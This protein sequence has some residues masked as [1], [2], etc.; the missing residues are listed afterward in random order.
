MPASGQPW[1]PLFASRSPLY[2]PYLQLLTDWSE[3][4]NWPD[5]EHYR[6]L[7][8]RERASRAPELKPLDFQ[9]MAPRPRRARQRIESLEQ[10]Y[11]GSIALRAQVPCLAA[12]YHDL[13]N[14]L[15]FAAF[16]R[17][18]RALHERQFRALRERTPALPARLPGARTTE[19]DAL[20]IFDEGGSVLVLSERAAGALLS[21]EELCLDIDDPP[22]ALVFGHAIL[23][24]ALSPTEA[25]PPLR[26]SALLLVGDELP[27]P[28]Q[29]LDRVDRFL[30]ARL[31]SERDFLDT[32][33]EAILLVHPDGRLRATRG[34][35]AA[36]PRPL[37]CL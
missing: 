11:D 22:R 36:L 18:K 24:H 7:V 15:M 5:A 4:P 3:R 20:T 29:L 31:S 12:S 26:S 28:R 9:T 16:P 33:S 21:G 27:E 34:R 23:E 2:R 1:D 13:F 8:E 35:A 19:Q 10:L 30:A 6:S 37:P 25:A 17:A 14:A 32:A